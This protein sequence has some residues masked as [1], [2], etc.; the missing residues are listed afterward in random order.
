MIIGQFDGF[1][2]WK[3]QSPQKSAK[4]TVEITRRLMKDAPARSTV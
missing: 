3:E 4:I 2:Q 1:Y